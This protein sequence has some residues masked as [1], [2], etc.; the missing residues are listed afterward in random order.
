MRS[1]VSRLAR[2]AAPRRHVREGVDEQGS[3]GVAHGGVAPVGVGGVAHLRRLRGVRVPAEGQLAPFRLQ[4]AAAQ[5]ALE[6]EAV[7][8]S[9]V[10]EALDLAQQAVDGGVL[11]LERVAGEVRPAARLRGRLDALVREEA[12][13]NHGSA[14]VLQLHRVLVARQQRV[15]HAKGRMQV[16]AQVP[17]RA[18]QQAAV[19]MLFNSGGLGRLVLRLR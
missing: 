8:D 18:L 1:S 13:R 5:V 3:G 6:L 9:P 7:V 14:L 12:Q 16:L 17:R 19:L 4:R 11:V 10:V 2:R 15:V